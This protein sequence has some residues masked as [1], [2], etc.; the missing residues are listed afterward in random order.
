VINSRRIACSVALSECCSRTAVRS[1]LSLPPRGQ[2]AQPA[3]GV[4]FSLAALHRYEHCVR[5]QD[6]KSG[7]CMRTLRPVTEKDSS[8]RLGGGTP[9]DMHGMDYSCLYKHLKQ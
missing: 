1:W 4:I 8:V 9:R 6:V 7:K 3:C 5:S 2:L